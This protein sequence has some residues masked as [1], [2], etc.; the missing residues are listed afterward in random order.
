MNIVL[1]IIDTLR[2]DYVGANG[3]PAIRT[4]NLDRLAARSW[5]FH[6]A[7]SASYPTIPM[8]T[9]VMTGRYGAPFH[10]W[11]PLDC[12]KPTIPQ[13]LAALGYGT[14][15]IHDTPHLV[16]GGH[17]FDFP[18]HA[19]TPVRGAEVDRAWLTDTWTY[20]PNWRLDPMFDPLPRDD[21]AVLRQ[22]WRTGGGY[23]HT[24]RGRT[25]EEDW[26]VAKLFT[27]AARFLQDNARRDNFF[28][29]ID[30]FDPHEPW[31]S[32]PEF[33][34]LYDRTPGYDGKLDPRSFGAGRNSTQLG[35]RAVE[36]LKA[37]YAAKVTFM[38]KWLGVFLDT[39]EATGLAG[40]TAV[41]LTADHGTNVGDRD[42]RHFGKAAPPRANEAH[43]PLMVR[44][45][46]GGSGESNLIVQPQDLFATVLAIAG[47]QPPEGTESH[48]VVK[49]AQERGPG[50]RRGQR[51]LALCGRSIDTW[52]QHPDGV[53]FST[54]DAA[55]C[56]GVTARP[57]RSELR[58]LHHD[59]DVAAQHPD[60]V[61]AL[62]AAALEEIARRGLDPA[63][64]AWLRSEGTKPFPTEY[65]ATD[66]HPPPPAWRTYF[67]NLYLG[68]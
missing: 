14:Q 10:R 39:L 21:E 59:Q 50:Q 61:A 49:L 64:V 1:I 9:D 54:L 12:D 20:L 5:N 17:S 15:L 24:N 40:R 6:R 46:D 56:L 16:N 19:W 48:N 38:D 53:L 18:F 8:R 65:R 34:R 4:P 45:P 51:R 58:R 41:V 52:S 57:E 11:K 62:R 44:V 2:Y 66:A 7:F 47:G 28:L 23:L 37:Q 25:R 55:W 67:Q 43:V 36:H 22:G 32:P 27:T 60:V 68:E 35:P 63:L 31:D 29:W 13:A 26:N 30:C 3:N 33:V 42:G